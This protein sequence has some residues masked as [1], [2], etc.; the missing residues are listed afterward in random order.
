MCGGVGGGVGGGGGGGGGML[1][2]GSFSHALLPHWS[3]TTLLL[4]Y[5]YPGGAYLSSLSFSLFLAEIA[6]NSVRCSP[7][8]CFHCS[9][10]VALWEIEGVQPNVCVKLTAIVH[11]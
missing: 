7:P 1:Y 6:S 10:R 2:S 11:G 8:R 3:T 9:S 5:M 4:T